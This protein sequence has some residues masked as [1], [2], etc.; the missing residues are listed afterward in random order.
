MRDQDCI[1]W[2]LE[3][4][5]LPALLD[6]HKRVALLRRNLEQGHGTVRGRASAGV[7]E[8]GGDS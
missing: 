3:V 7:L 4:R 6:P 5:R 1:F 2:T 8:A